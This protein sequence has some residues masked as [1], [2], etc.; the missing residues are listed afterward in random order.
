[1]IIKVSKVRGKRKN[2]TKRKP[3]SWGKGIGGADEASENNLKIVKIGISGY[4]FCAELV[5]GIRSVAF[6]LIALTR[7]IRVKRVFLV[8]S[9]SARI[10]CQRDDL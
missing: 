6:L 4:V 7:A 10:D 3:G 2:L 9:P 1:M 8:V 5:G